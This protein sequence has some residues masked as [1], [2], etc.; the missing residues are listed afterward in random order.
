MFKIQSV[1]GI[2]FHEKNSKVF[3]SA[4]CG[5]ST[6]NRF[7]TGNT[8]REATAIKILAG[9]WGSDQGIAPQLSH[10]ILSKAELGETQRRRVRKCGEVF[11]SS[12]LYMNLTSIGS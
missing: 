3:A 2:T 7:A 10:Q 11:P 8:A 1:S 9:G 12:Q 5:H 4:T 6:R